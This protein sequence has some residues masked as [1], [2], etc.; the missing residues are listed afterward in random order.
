METGRPKEVEEH[1]HKTLAHK[2]FTPNEKVSGGTE[3]FIDIDEFRV[4]QYLKHCDDKV[5]DQP[6][7]L[8]DL[9][10][11]HLGQFLSP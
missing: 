4:I 10:Y 8:S 6:T 1:I 11:K 7:G 2:R 9:D 3:M 5:F